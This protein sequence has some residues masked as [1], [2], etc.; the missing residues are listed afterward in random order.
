MLTLEEYKDRDAKT[1]NGRFS[2]MRPNGT[3]DSIGQVVDGKL[4][5]T[6]YFF[7]DTGSVIMRK[8]YSMG[9]L[10]SVW[11]ASDVNNDK[12]DTSNYDSDIESVFP[13]VAGSWRRYLMKNM[14]YPEAAVS[15][16]I[17]GTVIIYFKINAEGIVKDEFLVKSVEFNLDDEAIRLIKQSPKWKPAIQ[18]GRKVESYKLQPIEFRIS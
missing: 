17:Q 4:Y 13:G 1:P 8:E 7:C 12:K 2:Y 3:L 16:Q 14:K 18:K 15:K 6:W 11:K 9:R 10:I 5:G